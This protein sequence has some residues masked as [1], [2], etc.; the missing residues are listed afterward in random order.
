METKRCNVYSFTFLQSYKLI[1]SL[2]L[3]EPA[4]SENWDENIS[5]IQMVLVVKE[6]SNSASESECQDRVADNSSVLFRT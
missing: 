4:S 5:N 6:T 1:I 2:T 3:A